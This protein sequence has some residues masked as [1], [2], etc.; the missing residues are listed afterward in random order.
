[1]LKGYFEGVLSVTV[2]L[3]LAL[4]MSH[5]RARGITS[6]AAGVLLICAILLPLVDIFNDFNVDSYLDDLLKNT[7]YDNVTDDM[8]EEAFEKGVSEY[9]AD[10]YGVDGELVLVM[11]DGFD[12]ESLTAQ[13]IYVT[14]CKQAATLDYKKIEE[15]V[16]RLFTSGGECEV[17]LKIG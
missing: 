1:M 8:I 2:F 16:S 17:S 15:D 14:L 5:I 3:A 7:E 10:E 4:G 12:M 13:R 11:A 9:I 6:F